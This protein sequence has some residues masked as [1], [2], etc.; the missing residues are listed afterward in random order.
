M[1][2]HIVK[3]KQRDKKIL[4]STVRKGIHKA[5]V[6]RRAN[7]LLLSNKGKKDEEIKEITGACRTAIWNTRK[8]YCEEG[9]D[10]VLYDEQRSGAPKVFTQEQRTKVIAIACTTPKEGHSHWSLKLLA[11]E[12]V[13]QGVVPKISHEGVRIILQEHDLKPH[14]KKNVVCSNVR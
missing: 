10:R 11:K 13:K 5:S 2:K 8:H 14:L 9:L 4:K 6:I 3:L 7:I 1:K 12:A